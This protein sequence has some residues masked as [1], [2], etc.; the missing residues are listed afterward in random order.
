MSWNVLNFFPRDSTGVS[1]TTMIVEEGC[2]SQIQ[3]TQKLE[4]VP[5]LDVWS[6]C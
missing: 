3:H 1:D 5:L 2:F 4:M 6:S